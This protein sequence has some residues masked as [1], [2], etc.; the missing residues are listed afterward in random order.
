[1]AFSLSM[2]SSQ[3]LLRQFS[4]PRRPTRFLL[5]NQMMI[6]RPTETSRPP[7]RSLFQRHQPVLVI[8]TSATNQSA[9][10][11]M[12]VTQ[13]SSASPQEEPITGKVEPISEM[14]K[15]FPPAVTRLRHWNHS[16]RTQDPVLMM[17][18]PHRPTYSKR[19]CRSLLNHQPIPQE[20]IRDWQHFNSFR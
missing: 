2:Q 4:T 20:E 1:M 15:S 13:R 8:H 17:K 14:L 11:E 5:P 9:T 3:K 10:S 12:T 19:C 18:G 6:W 7:S 16:G